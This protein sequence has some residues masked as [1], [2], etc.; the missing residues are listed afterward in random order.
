MVPGG[1]HPRVATRGRD[2]ARGCRAR[3]AGRAWS[4]SVSR[5]GGE[6]D[7]VGRR[8]VVVAV[9]PAS[10]GRGRPGRPAAGGGRGWSR[11]TGARTT[12]SAGC[13]G[14][15]AVRHLRPSDDAP[16]VSRTG[17]RFTPAHVPVQSRSGRVHVPDSRRSVQERC[18]H[19]TEFVPARPPRVVPPTVVTWSIRRRST[20]PSRARWPPVSRTTGRPRS[21]PD[22][23]GSSAS[24]RRPEAGCAPRVA[25]GSRM[26]AG[27][28][29]QRP[30]ASASAAAH[31]R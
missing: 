7:Q 17:P 15:R 31:G 22:G 8:P 27:F 10:R 13:R 5:G 19:R 18:R 23:V 28:R 12:R 3:W 6:G 4:R 1:T 20:A 14:R 11:L 24:S 16:R 21:A 9:G 25:A 30:A 26:P 29:G 2:G